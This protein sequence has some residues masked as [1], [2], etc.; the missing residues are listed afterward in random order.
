MKYLPIFPVAIFLSFISSTAF[1]SPLTYSPENLYFST[2]IGASKVSNLDNYESKGAEQDE[3]YES[4]DNEIG[5]AFSLQAGYKFDLGIIAEIG[6]LN[7]GK[8]S[9]E[10]TQKQVNDSGTVLLEDIDEITL[11]PSGFTL[12]VGYELP[13]SDSISLTGKVG[14]FIWDLDV[15]SEDTNIDHVTSE[16]DTGIKDDSFAPNEMAKV[17]F[18]YSYNKS[19]SISAFNRYV[20]KSTDL[21]ITRDIPLNNKI[22]ESY[23]LLTANLIWD[24]GQNFTQIEKGVSFITLYLDNILDEEI[25][26]PDVINRGKNNSIPSHYGFNMNLSFKYNF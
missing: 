13:L 6:Y 4:D 25:F 20:G 14:M 3:V 10:E 9:F 24:L 15:E 17:G 7:L 18:V 8:V 12:G 26:A 21:N 22:P 16:T 23:N 19:L 5:A 1:A 2:S 11:K